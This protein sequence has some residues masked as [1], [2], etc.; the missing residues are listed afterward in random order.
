MSAAI[1]RS[2]GY[3]AYA[4]RRSAT[5]DRVKASASSSSQYSSAAG[6]ANIQRIM[7]LSSSANPDRSPTKKVASEFQARMSYRALTT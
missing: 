6:L 7:F 3:R 5:T 4:A 2:P 1:E